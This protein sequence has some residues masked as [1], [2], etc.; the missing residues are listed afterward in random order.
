MLQTLLINYASI[1]KKHFL[2]VFED[3]EDSNR[4]Y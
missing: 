3:H 4:E 1:K 2:Y